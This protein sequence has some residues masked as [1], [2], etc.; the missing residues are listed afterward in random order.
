MAESHA[1]TSIVG[2]RRHR[3]HPRPSPRPCRAP[4]S[5]SSTPTPSTSPRSASDGLTLVRG[6]RPRRVAAWPALHAGRDGGPP[7]S[8]GCCSRSRRRPPSA[9]LDWI[10]P[11]L[12][13][14]GFVVSLQNGLNEEA[15]R[16]AGSAPSAPSARSSTCSPTSIGPGVIRDGGSGGP[17]RRRARRP[18]RRR[19]ARGRRRPAGL[20][21][22]PSHR[23]RR[24]VPVVQA[25]VR[26]D[27]RR[28]RARRRADGRPDRPAPAGDARAGGRGLRRRGGR[29]D[30]AG[31]VRRL[32]PR[33]PTPATDEA[34]RKDAATDA[35]VAWLRT[36][37]EGPQ[38]HLARHRRA[39]PP[40]GGPHALRARCSP[41]PPGTASPAG[42]WSGSSTHIG[43]LEAGAAMAEERIAA[44]AGALR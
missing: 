29:G 2:G 28:D 35:L 5:P 14:D 27:A 6:D 9:P 23:Q 34:R 33:C 1:A 36:Q 8:S 15:H 17:R 39:A 41:S 20:G 3:R 30:R 44:L 21:P 38:R 19:V 43:E 42:V 22:G 13:A 11:R 18:D 7:G 4:G 32:R 24:R 12:A 25:R 40:D 16:R 26:R 10:A 31:A 37:A